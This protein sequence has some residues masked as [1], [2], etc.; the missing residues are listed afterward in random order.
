LNI[1]ILV[2]FNEKDEDVTFTCIVDGLKVERKITKAWKS[3]PKNARILNE[4]IK[5]QSLNVAIQ[6]KNSIKIDRFEIKRLPTEI[7]PEKSKI[8]VRFFLFFFFISII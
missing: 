2:E 7:I 3:C 1:L 4:I 6:L 5:E 8:L